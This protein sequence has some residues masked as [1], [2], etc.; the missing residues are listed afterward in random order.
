MRWF[1]WG[2]T[3]FNGVLKSMEKLGSFGLLADIP[4]QYFPGARSANAM[5]PVKLSPLF[6]VAPAPLLQL[7]ATPSEKR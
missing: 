6:S 1:V 7:P 2:G 5:V 3:E 4:M